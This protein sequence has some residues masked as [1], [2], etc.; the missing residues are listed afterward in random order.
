MNEYINSIFLQIKMA[1]QIVKKLSEKDIEFKKWSKNE[2][3]VLLELYHIICSNEPA[4]LDFVYSYHGCDS[5]EDIF[6]DYDKCLLSDKKDGV[7][8][9]LDNFEKWESFYDKNKKE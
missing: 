7:Q 2:R 8:V 5:W 1:D 4:I 6:R 3:Q 9:A